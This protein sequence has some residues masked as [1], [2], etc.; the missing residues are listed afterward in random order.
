MVSISRLNAVI[1]VLMFLVVAFGDQLSRFFGIGVVGFEY[2]I[3][4]ALVPLVVIVNFGVNSPTILTKPTYLFV[5]LVLLLICALNYFFVDVAPARY[6]QGSFFTFLFAFNFLLFYNVRISVKDFYSIAKVLISIITMIAVAAY[7]ERILAEGVY[8]SYFLR[9]VKTIAK[10]PGMATTLFNA[11][12]VLCFVM[13]L[14]ERRRIYIYL[15]CFSVVTIGLLLFLKA[16]V[17]ALL[18]CFVFISIYLRSKNSKYLLYAF[19]IFFFC[20][21]VV[22][23]KPL[24]NEIQYKMTLYFGPG[25][26]KTPRN[27]L[28]IA[29]FEIAGDYFPFG[30]G[31]GTF[32]SYPVGKEYSDIYYT[33]GLDKLH[34]LGKED[35]LGKTDAQ[36]VFDAYWSSIIGEMGF[37]AAVLYLWLWFLPAFGSYRLMWSKD[38]DVKALAFFVTMVT[39]GIFVESIASPIPGQL[40]FILIYAGLGAVVYRLIRQHRLLIAQS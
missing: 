10:D 32:G 29:S 15:I 36:F 31:Q 27:A 7:I 20:S 13:Y 19:S 1:F 2:Y 24:W 39:V 11:N 30:S 38:R 6:L 8:Q 37:V 9:G 3:W 4:L 18:I 16:F 23:G 17:V 21:L 40:Q 28:Y 22:L 33:Y 25:S 35:A 12:I 5:L 26:S 14:I 34:G